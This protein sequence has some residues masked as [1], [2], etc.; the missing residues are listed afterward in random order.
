VHGGRKK[1]LAAA[2]KYRD[3]AEKKSAAARR[4]PELART[5]RVQASAH[6]EG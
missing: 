3:E 5:R 6:D 4:P 1:A 2:V